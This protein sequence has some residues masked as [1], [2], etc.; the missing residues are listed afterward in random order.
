M[1]IDGKKIRDEILNDVKK[2]VALL[3]YVPVFCDVLVGDDPVSAQYVRMKAKTAE[4]VGIKFR[5]ADFPA[6]ITTEE[7]IGHIEDLNHVPAMCGIIVQLPL[8]PHIDKEKV[9]NAIAPSLDVDCLGES[10]SEKFYADENPIGFPTALACMRVLDS[11]GVDFTGKNIVVL[12][13]GMLV[14]R[15]VAHLL[16]S[17]GLKVTVVH[18]KTEN[19]EDLIKN[20]DVIIS[21]IG[22]GKFITGDKIKEGAII[23]DAG[24]SEDNG[25]VVGDVDL[26]SVQ[27]VASYVTP[28]PG[29]VGPVTVGILLRN[30]L[31]V[32]E[33]KNNI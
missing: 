19:A 12:G 18:S 11:T 16:E 33:R 14:G 1:I 4:S 21:A 7:L 20:A 23:I 25:G 10:A 30:V 2:S 24:T 13:R 27:N 5:S 32:A 9:L 6:S 3:P 31:A 22:K 17:R 15:P 8:P 26:E 29:G 28:A